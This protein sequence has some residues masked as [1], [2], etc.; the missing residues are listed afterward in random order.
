MFIVINFGK[1][2]VRGGIP[3]IDMIIKGVIMANALWEL[4]AVCSWGCV[5][6]DKIFISENIGINKITYIE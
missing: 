5:V 2:P 4:Q 1:K 3:L 6:I